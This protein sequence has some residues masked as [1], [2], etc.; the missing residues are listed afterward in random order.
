MLAEL[1]R[2]GINVRTPNGDGVA[3][4]A[5][6]SEGGGIDSVRDTLLIERSTFTGNRASVGGGIAASGTGDQQIVSSTISGNQARLMGGGVSADQM[7][8]QSS[9]IAGNTI[10]GSGEPD[11]NVSALTG[12]ANVIGG[13]PQLSALGNFGGGVPTLALAGTSPAV[14]HGRCTDSTDQRGYYIVDARCD[15]GAYELGATPTRPTPQGSLPPPLGGEFGRRF[16]PVCPAEVLRPVIAVDGTFVRSSGEIGS[17][18]VIR[19]GVIA[20]VDVFT[21][22][23]ASAAGAVICFAG[24]GEMIFLSADQAPR[25]PRSLASRQI[26]GNTCATLPGDGT[27]VLVAH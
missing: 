18:D 15:A 2:D 9:I 25:V 17:A 11:A 5:G 26:E 10:T 20:A 23:G 27:L 7:T 4:Q 21:L 12:V 1:Q 16:A 24:D 19:R 13:D 6:A 22:N 8:I 3:G 14:N